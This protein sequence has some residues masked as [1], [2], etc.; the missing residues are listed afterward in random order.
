MKVFVYDTPDRVPDRGRPGC[1]VV[2]DVLRATTTLAAAL[3]SGAEAVRVCGD[4]KALLRESDAWPK[5]RRV[6]IGERAGRR[7]AGF[8]RDNSPSVLTPEE[9]LG[10]RVFMSTTNGTRAFDRVRAAPRVLAAALVNRAAV[11]RHLISRPTPTVWIVCSGWEGAYALE[12][13]ACAGAILIGLARS[14]KSRWDRLAGND[15]AVAAAALYRQWESRLPVLLRR[16]E[17]GRRLL[18][19]GREADVRYCSKI[20]ILDV[21]PRQRTPGLMVRA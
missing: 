18:R 2:V 19:L 6:R 14:V 7:V 4:L 3:A 11:V 15:E 8:E 1:A 10:R 9:L 21:V 13:A 5:C 16:A 17:H 20:D 12:D